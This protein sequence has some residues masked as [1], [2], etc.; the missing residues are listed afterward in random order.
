MPSPIAYSHLTNAQCRSNDTR[1][2]DC[3]IDRTGVNNSCDQSEQAGVVCFQGKLII[4]HKWEHS[5][6]I[7]ALLIKKKINE[8]LQIR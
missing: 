4:A 6:L 7:Y 2:S 8:I 1:L 5:L 3:D